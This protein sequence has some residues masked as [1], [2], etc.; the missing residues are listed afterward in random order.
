M[1]RRS[2][3][4]LDA[5]VA[6]GDTFCTQAF[7]DSS[8]SLCN[9]MGRTANEVSQ[10]GEALTPTS[11]ALE[12][13][14]YGGSAGVGLFLAEL[15]AFTGDDRHRRTAVGAMRRSFRHLELHPRKGVSSLSFF[16]GDLGVAFAARRVSRLLGAPELDAP[17]AEILG[18]VANAV[19]EPH[20]L[21]VIGGN[22]GAIP[23]LVALDHVR[24]ADECRKLAI[25]LGDQMLRSGRQEGAVWTWNPDET[26]GPEMASEPLAG[27][28]HGASGM[29][30]ALFELHA[31]T[32]RSEFLDAARGAF[33][34][35]D[36][37]FDSRQGNW[38]DLRRFERF[39]VGRAETGFA[40]AWCHGAPGIALARLRASVLDPARADEHLATA[41]TAID[42]TLRG[43]DKRLAL[44]TADTS[45]CTDLP[46]LRRSS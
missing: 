31:A 7:W 23:A 37:L 24:P 19:G 11:A 6:I 29:G 1:N 28:A 26:S 12:A 41:R 40:V 27:L 39:E 17:V 38:P 2:S 21:D 45:L 43:I 42:T 3:E 10:R 46:G 4:F 22:A 25:I 5:A 15:G 32:G 16:R 14:L 18:R 44:A 30:L 35:E 9:W 13:E 36:A 20:D 33:A 34:Y 8:G